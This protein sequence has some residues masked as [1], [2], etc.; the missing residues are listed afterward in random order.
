MGVNL[1][2]FD[3]L[4]CAPFTLALHLW[5]SYDITNWCKI[6]TKINSW[7][8]KSH[9]LEDDMRNLANFHQSTRKSRN[10]DFDGILLSNV[11]NV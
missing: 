8:Q 1:P 9:G 2:L 11:E 5:F 4:R 7:F 6:C 3:S 10:C